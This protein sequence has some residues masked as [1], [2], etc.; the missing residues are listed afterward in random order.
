MTRTFFSGRNNDRAPARQTFFPVSKTDTTA[1]PARQTTT[2]EIFFPVVIK[3]SRHNKKTAYFLP[4]P[5]TDTTAQPA[6]QTTK[7]CFF[8]VV[9]KLSCHNRKTDTTAQLYCTLSK[10]VT[11]KTISRQNKK[12]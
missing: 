1:Q 10:Y 5:K 8:P 7:T 3:L 9:I 12:N 6:R 4:E 2:I 11:P